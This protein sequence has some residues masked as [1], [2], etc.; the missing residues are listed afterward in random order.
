MAVEWVVS[1]GNSDGIYLADHS[2]E[3]SLETRESQRT[4]LS[5]TLVLKKT[6]GVWLSGTAPD[7]DSGIRWFESNRPNQINSRISRL[8]FST[9]MH[10]GKSNEVH[11]EH[12]NW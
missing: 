9:T 7:F 1:I 5:N 12:R 4:S 10:G 11:Q 8:F 2:M 3:W 6:F